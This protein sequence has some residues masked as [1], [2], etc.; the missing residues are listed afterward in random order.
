MSLAE[1]Q[2]VELA[3]E[4]P[5]SG[6]RMI[7]R[8]HGQVVLV[9]G[10]IPGERV[11]ALVER[12]EKRMAYAVTRDVVEPSPD[13]RPAA[14]DPL[15]GGA[16]YSHIAYARQLAIKSDV[17][18][19]AF[20]RGGRYPID[21]AV[22]VAAS[23]EEGYRMR[24][25][26]HV[27]G[28]RAGFY[29]EGTHQLCDA[30]ATRQLR[31]EALEAVSVLAAALARELPGAVTSIA[32][33]EN[34][35]GDQRAAHIELRSTQGQTRVKPGSDKGQ[36][37]VKLG[38]DPF[39]RAFA[40]AK[41][42]G[43]SASDLTT[44]DPIAVGEPI[45]VEPLRALTD[46]RVAEGV[47]QRH[48]E[49]FFQGNRFLIPQLVTAV[50]DLVPDAGEVLDLY[51]GVGL[52]S[53]ALAA[54]GRLDVTAVEGDRASG[55]DLR[56]NARAHEPRLNAHLE[57]VERF[58]SKTLEPPASVIVDPPRTGMSPD[59][60]AA[61]VRLRAERIVYVSC[62]PP[63]LA[64]DA[65]RLI[66]AGYALASLRAFDFFPNTPHVESLA[67]FTRAGGLHE[68]GEEA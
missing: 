65:R 39:R 4:K 23:P 53:V 35:A 24:A 57:S 55:A 37:G 25:R 50:A 20:A 38:S 9:R 40:E 12:A 16:L 7:A 44:G 46:G 60:L 43:I 41:L 14:A 67:L 63:T 61:V 22:D 27:H 5:A 15:C 30:A 18:R 62:D 26:F 45:V 59:A 1:G 17:I 6:G 3:I 8:H 32:I 48:A 19:D 56:E 49:S 66:D 31:P 68:R 33:A 36:T 2:L 54:M 47:L 52:F 51:A 11:K 29:R 13:R 42:R 64:R 58:L 21:R 34:V 10:A 28:A